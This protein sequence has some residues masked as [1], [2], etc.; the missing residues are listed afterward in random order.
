MA[1]ENS[2]LLLGYWLLEL[3]LG[4]MSLGPS[5]WKAGMLGCWEDSNPRGLEAE[6]HKASCQYCSYSLPASWPSSFLAS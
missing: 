1:G 2:N 5:S 6:K 4:L 3:D